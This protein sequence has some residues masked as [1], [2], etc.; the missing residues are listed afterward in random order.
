MSGSCYY[1]L[2]IHSCLSPCAADDMTPSNIAGMATI[3]GLSIIA[4]TDH[5]SGRNLPAM[6]KAAEEFGLAF[7]PGIEVTTVEEVHVLTYFKDLC[8]AVEFGDMLYASL[9][10]ISNRPDIFGCQILMDELDEPMGELDK[11]LLQATPFPITELTRMAVS[12]GGCAVPA[13]INRDSFS[14]F[15]NLGFLPPGLFN[16]VEV[17]AC[18]PCPSLD[19]SIQILHSSDAHQLGDISEPIRTT[20]LFHDAATLVDFINCL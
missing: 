5:N 1:D 13:H 9:P 14:V 8:T 3:K 12:A 16:T 2:H 15:A 4:L 17:C 7:V 18:L 10:G 11:L 20:S 19:P 6:S